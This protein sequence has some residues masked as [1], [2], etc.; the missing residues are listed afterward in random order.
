MADIKIFVSHRI[1]LNSE[2]IDNALYCPL[3]CG[4]A[5]DNKNLSG[6]PGDD[7]G[8]NISAQ[9]EYFSEFTVQYW[10]WK[11]TDSDYYGLCH[12]RRYL[13]FSDKNYKTDENNMVYAPVM[14][15]SSKK[16]FGLEEEKMRAAIESY[17]I[18]TSQS[19]EVAKMPTPRGRQNTVR[20]WWEAQD[21]RYL[22]KET[23]D[24]MLSLIDELSP[25]YSGSAR[26]YLAGGRFR[27]SNCYVL[28]K[29][30]F[31]RLCE[32]EF[33]IMFEI[34][35]RLGTAI[36]KIPRTPAYTGEILYGIFMHHM[37]RHENWRVLELQLV[38][39]NDTRKIRGKAD[40]AGRRFRY[41]ADSIFRPIADLLLPKG[42]A[43]RER[44]KQILK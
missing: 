32:F 31:I 9:S 7:S 13:S 2:C 16:R 14:L 36:E 43:M 34:K 27:G 20:A 37:L 21:G 19:A 41:A 17:D 44:V 24:L 5:A 11:N 15:S 40:L 4:A 3:R 6:L 33:P 10:A 30:L 8:D 22:D 25:A 29:E 42:G 23:L 38:F 39:F 1:D 26:E 28:C 12:Y 35:Q 18:V